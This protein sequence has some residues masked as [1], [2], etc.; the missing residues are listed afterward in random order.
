MH[1][2]SALRASVQSSGSKGESPDRSQGKLS[3]RGGIELNFE[4]CVGDSQVKGV[5]GHWVKKTL[6]PEREIQR[7]D[8]VIE[9]QRNT[10]CRL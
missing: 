1:Q 2:S 3:G 7:Q 9:R 8:R 5:K 10:D 4:G 6:R